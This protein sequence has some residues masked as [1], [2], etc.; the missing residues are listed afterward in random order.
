MDAPMSYEDALRYV[1]DQC[2][3]GGGPKRLAEVDVF[4]G[5]HRNEWSEVREGLRLAIERIR[6]DADAIP[7]T[8]ADRGRGGIEPN[9][10]LHLEAAE[11]ALRQP[12]TDRDAYR[13]VSVLVH[14]LK[15]VTLKASGAIPLQYQGEE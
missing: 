7:W 6:S 9:F 12:H 1:F 15:A 2:G 10:T 3:R 5:G 14:A 8:E 4:R 11:E 13:V